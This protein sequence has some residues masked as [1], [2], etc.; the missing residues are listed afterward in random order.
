M[1]TRVLGSLDEVVGAVLCATTPGAQLAKPIVARPTTALTP[2][3]PY[4]TDPLAHPRQ[5]GHSLIGVISDQN[6]PNVSLAP[7]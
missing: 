3:S 1:S 4:L 7:W 2:L 5:A 6:H